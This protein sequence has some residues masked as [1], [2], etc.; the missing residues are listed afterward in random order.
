M[1]FAF[2]AFG[3][4]TFI[5]C[6][7]PAWAAQDTIPS[8]GWKKETPQVHIERGLSLMVKGDYDGGFK[9]LF[10]RNN[11]KEVLE[12]LKFEVYRLAKKSGKPNGFENILK[13]KAGASIMRYRYLLLFDAKPLIFDFY[14]YKKKKGWTLQHINYNIDIRKVFAQ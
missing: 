2:A 7:A 11:K 5:L 8:S 1:R 3:L 14:Y 12:K 13:Q 6:A 4:L 10:G 9:A